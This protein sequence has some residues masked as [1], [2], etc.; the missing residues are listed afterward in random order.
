[1]TIGQFIITF[2]IMNFSWQPSD[3]YL[4]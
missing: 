2:A 4:D 3:K 1:L